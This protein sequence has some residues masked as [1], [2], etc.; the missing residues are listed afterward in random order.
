MLKTLIIRKD[1]LLN[2]NSKNMRN[3]SVKFI[4]ILL[5][6]TSL[7]S[8]QRNSIEHYQ[9]S[10]DNLLQPISKTAKEQDVRDVTD[11][12]GCGYMKELDPWY[13]EKLSNGIERWGR[14]SVWHEPSGITSYGGFV[15]G[16]DEKKY[17]YN[18]VKN[19]NYHIIYIGYWQYSKS[20]GKEIRFIAYTGRGGGDV[21]YQFESINDKNKLIPQKKFYLNPNLHDVTDK[22]GLCVVKWIANYGYNAISEVKSRNP[23]SKNYLVPT[24]KIIEAEE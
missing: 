20:I 14:R 9:S 22:F 10:I 8:C 15:V 2:N 24:G 16:Y 12:K 5:L 6:M 17:S 23:F 1:S 7:Y 4:A 21:N 19:S 11:M 18:L 3:Y 13:K